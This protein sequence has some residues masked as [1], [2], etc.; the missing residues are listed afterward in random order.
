MGK[1]DGDNA[2]M[3][4]KQTKAL[5]EH[6][7]APE[8]ASAIGASRKAALKKIAGLHGAEALGVVRAKVFIRSSSIKLNWITNGGY[9][10]GRIYEIAGRYSSGKTT[11]SFDA[12]ANAQKQFPDK[13]CFFIDAEQ[14]FDPTWAAKF[15]VDISRLDVL[16]PPNMQAAWDEV[17]VLCMSGAY[18][19]GVVDS[20]AALATAEE[21][22]T[23]TAGAKDRMGNSAAAISI[24][25]KRLVRPVSQSQTCLILLNQM[26]DNLSPFS[27]NK[28]MI[29]GGNALKHYCSVRMQVS[30][31]SGS[32]EKD[33][34]GDVTGHT[35]KIFVE[36]NKV[37]F[38]KRQTEL[39][40][41]FTKAFDTDSELFRLAREMEIVTREKKKFWFKGREVCE[42]SEEFLKMLKKN[43][44]FKMKVYEAVDKSF[45]AGGEEIVTNKEIEEIAKDAPDTVE[46]IEVLE[47]I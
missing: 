33:D 9:C 15:G 22:L 28:P 8:G 2:K 36:K 32:E 18:S 5:K 24:G 44:K 43:Y 31:V 29:P 6:F 41:S 14:S 40:L 13:N 4:N 17:R 19:L 1:E 27:G 10:L 21:L 3:S 20:V 39:G 37:G 38:P 42:T 35:I 47:D 11:L 25:L 12:I 34:N 30:V 26:R 46:E 7:V 45:K 23:D 16:D